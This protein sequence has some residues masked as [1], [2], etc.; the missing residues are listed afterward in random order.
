MPFKAVTFVENTFKQV[1]GCVGNLLKV[2]QMAA[3]QEKEAN[4]N[5]H[6]KVRHNF[7]QNK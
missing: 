5:C 7:K 1:G 2:M 6:E 4:R 3:E